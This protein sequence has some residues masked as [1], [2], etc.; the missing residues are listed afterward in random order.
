MPRG[1]SSQTTISNLILYRKQNY[2][3]GL[4]GFT[5]PSGLIIFSNGRDSSL[6]LMN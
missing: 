5:A 3:C 2:L 1:Y 4:R 6:F